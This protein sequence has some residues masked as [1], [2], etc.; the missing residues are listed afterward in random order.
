MRARGVRVGWASEMNGG[1]GDLPP[2]DGWARG[3]AGSM[4]GFWM[5]F[6][7][8]DFG[9]ICGG[10][11]ETA[12]SVGECSG[13]VLWAVGGKA[14]IHSQRDRIAICLTIT[15][16]RTHAHHQFD[17]YLISRSSTSVSTVRKSLRIPTMHQATD[18]SSVVERWCS[19]LER[20]CPHRR[21]IGGWTAG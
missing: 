11:D 14:G 10:R 21:R 13:G 1:H 3:C 9:G 19:Q 12:I 15:E 18:H 2:A 17:G 4:L 20:S 7:Q 6:C 5:G 8:G 16:K